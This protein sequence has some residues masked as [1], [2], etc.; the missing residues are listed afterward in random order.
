MYRFITAVRKNDIPV[1]P[2]VFACLAMATRSEHVKLLRVYLKP[3]CKARKSEV[4]HSISTAV[5]ATTIPVKS[6]LFL[7]WPGYLSKLFALT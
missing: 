7:G 6:R 2:R 4:K 1:S 5:T 3:T